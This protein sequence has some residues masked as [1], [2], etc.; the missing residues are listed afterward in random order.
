MVTYPAAEAWMQK[1]DEISSKTM[2]KQ[3][4]VLTKDVAKQVNT[5][6]DLENLQNLNRT[7]IEE[8]TNVAPNQENIT[9]NF[10]SFA[11]ASQQ[12]NH[13]PELE[14]IQNSSSNLAPI[15][16]GN[17]FL[18]EQEDATNNTDSLTDMQSPQI[19]ENIQ[20]STYNQIQ[21]SHE[22]IEQ[23]IESQ[24]PQFDRDT[25]LQ[26]QPQRLNPG[27]PDIISNLFVDLRTFDEN[28][29]NSLQGNNFKASHQVEPSSQTE[30]QM[31]TRKK[32]NANPNLN[33]TLTVEIKKMREQRTHTSLLM[34]TE[35]EEPKSYKIALTLP[36]W[37]AAM[38]EEIKALNDSHTWN[39]ERILALLFFVLEVVSVV[40]D[41]IG[42]N[43]VDFL[44][45]ALLLSV[46]G[47]AITLC[48][49]IE[50]KTDL[51]IKAEIQMKVVEIVFSLIQLIVT[52]IQYLLTVLKAKN[53]YNASAFPL[54]YAI[55]AVVFM[56]IKD[57]KITDSST[58]LLP[59]AYFQ[60]IGSMTSTPTE[61]T[62]IVSSADQ[63]R[64]ESS[65]NHVKP[66]SSTNHHDK[67]E[68]STNQVK[69]GSSAVKTSTH[70]LNK[71]V[72]MKFEINDDEA[73]EKAMD[74]VFDDI[75]G[76]DSFLMD[77]KN[78]IWTVIGNIV[79]EDV[80]KLSKICKTQQVSA[81]PAKKPEEKKEEKRQE[82]PKKVVMKLEINDAKATKKAME[83]VVDT[84][85]VDSFSMDMKNNELTMKGN[86]V[87]EDVVIKL[88]KICKTEL[89]SIEPA[90]G[91]G[92]KKKEERTENIAELQ[93]CYRAY[94]NS[95]PYK[96]YDIPY[97][98]PYY[99]IKSEPAKE[100][101]K[102]EEKKLEPKEWTEKLAELAE[103]YKP[104]IPYKPN[105]KK[106][107]SE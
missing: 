50:A 27:M 30:H 15:Q 25:N 99:H 56:F 49:F 13:D 89:V 43:K 34:L 22:E 77:V 107:K 67:P 16:E 7:S 105:K 37:H 59:R 57:G 6:F 42:K 36:Q 78:N 29:G 47:F 21:E 81:E 94:Y 18:Q 31:I 9:N 64:P 41:L 46:F 14:I 70:A 53:D 76:V 84:S 86:I 19:F 85:G 26:D 20:G 97:E 65:K 55:I 58:E 73:N 61:L 24:A 39:L 75:S 101:K 95:R 80:I 103:L 51:T 52:F 96:P 66:E 44:L 1:K 48:S 28:A 10:D 23:N 98:N 90:K 8:G 33:P 17:G 104:D 45:A 93:K 88:R 4:E 11:D 71:K 83:T 2:A 3:H 92:E 102:K 106:I 79:E 69:P 82:E 63:V 54:A 38:K 40:L 5:N 60:P 62:E 72:V 87:A 12:P 74:T 68:S 91:P 32:L 35:N 100:E